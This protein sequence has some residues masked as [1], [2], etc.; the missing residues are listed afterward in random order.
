MTNKE[1]LIEEIQKLPDGSSFRQIAQEV[2]VIAAVRMGE[3]DAD[4]G[5]TIPHEEVVRRLRDRTSK[6]GGS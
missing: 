2:T 4:L 3:I 5:R 1:L 6:G